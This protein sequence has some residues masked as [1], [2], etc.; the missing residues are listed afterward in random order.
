MNLDLGYVLAATAFIH[1]VAVV[2]LAIGTAIDRRARLAR[3]ELR[4]AEL[5]A[6]ERAREEG[7]KKDPMGFRARQ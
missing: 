1:A 5:E 6:E 7:A 4:K 3:V 2:V